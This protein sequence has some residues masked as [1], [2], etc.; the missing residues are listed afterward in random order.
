[1]KLKICGMKYPINIKD[2]AALQ[3]DYL[4]FIFYEKSKRNFGG[5]IPEISNNIKKTGVFVNEAAE[6]VVEMVLK[7]QLSAVQLHGDESV[8]FCHGLR[9][10]FYATN[11]VEIIK[12][13]SVDENFDFKIVRT[14]E[15]VCDYFL[16][17]TKG[18]EKGGNGIT[19]NWEL[20][21]NY[22]SNKPYFLSGGLGLEEVGNL[23]EFIKSEVSRNCYALDVN[24]KFEIKPGLKNVEDLKL[25]IKDLNL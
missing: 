25:F 13:F 24:S 1:M 7:Y 9:Q 22:S 16:F 4:G 3:P 17:D 10:K 8:A 12:V 14:Y 19:F 2:V 15:N 21:K 18:K 23:K 5:K 20:L 6:V 11:K